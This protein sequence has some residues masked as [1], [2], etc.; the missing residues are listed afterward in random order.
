MRN[1][2]GILLLSSAALSLG[3]SEGGPVSY[4]RDVRPMLQANCQGCHQPAKAKGEYV[5]T[6]VAA[7][8]A[9]GAREELQSVALGCAELVGKRVA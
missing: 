8:I 2:C 4:W 9:G 1:L 7:L 6:D 3:G 5:M